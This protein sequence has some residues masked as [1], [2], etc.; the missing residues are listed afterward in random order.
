MNCLCSHTVFNHHPKM[1]RE[2]AVRFTLGACAVEGC[3]CTKY[4]VA[5]RGGS[6]ILDDARQT[7][8]E[9]IERKARAMIALGQDVLTR[10]REL[11]AG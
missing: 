10:V 7:E 1:E 6:A 4:V 5:G 11:K 9:V 2:G 3:G 8:L